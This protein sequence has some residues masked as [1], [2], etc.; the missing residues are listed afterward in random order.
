MDR[1]LLLLAAEDYDEARGALESARM[2]A[3]SAE[4]ISYG[5]SLMQEPEDGHHAAMRQL[6]A[7]QFLCPAYDSWMDAEA[8]WQGE[9][10]ILVGHPL[11][12]FEKN[13]D[14][15]LLHALSKCRRGGSMS[16]VLT[17]YLPRPQDPVDAVCPVAAQA[18][19]EEGRLCFHKGMPLRYAASPVRSAFLHPDFCFAPSAFFRDWSEEPGPRFLAAFRRK[20][21]VYTLHKP[22]LHMM[23][24][25]FVPPCGV[26]SED[27]PFSRFETRFSLKF[28]TRQLSAM[29]RQ[30]V[31]AADRACP[32]H[33]P[34]AVRAQEAVR[35]LLSRRSKLAP[36][37]V[38]AWVPQQ[39][40][41]AYMLE[42]YMCWFRHLSRLKALPLLCFAEGAMAK[43]VSLMH[44]N[45]LDYKA[46]YGLQARGSS[47]W[48]GTKTYARL[49]KAFL[50]AQARE[51]FLHHTH[52]IWMD[53]SYQRY[54]IYERAAFEWGNICQDKIT[55]AT[56]EGMPDLSMIAVPD[57]RVLTLCREL[58]ALCEQYLQDEERLPEEEEI[59]LRM[60]VEHPDWFC[61]VEMPGRRE[62]FTMTMMSREEEA[63]AYT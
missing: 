13:W 57:E 36:L 5:L 21:E 63:H 10:F 24:E 26:R 30:G 8:L 59:W 40:Q 3:A 50:L 54:P 38:T 31:C 11:M 6:G 32:M 1:I 56:V 7:V 33:V 42:E 2:N 17:G 25:A 9:G 39:E 22:V 28:A 29:A 19:D 35:D 62:L 18:F 23:G 4:R 58:T 61:T 45:M 15:H 16:S 47:R 46:R 12:R 44:P 52:Y 48:R 41:P 14:I 37:C 51:K 43:R 20:W 60:M 49:S 53:F 55:L 27:G 34:Y